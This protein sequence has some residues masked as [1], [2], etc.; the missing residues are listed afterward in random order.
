MNVRKTA[1][2]TDIIAHLSILHRLLNICI[3]TT[4][5]FWLSSDGYLPLMNWT[6]KQKTYDAK[7]GEEIAMQIRS[8]V[9]EDM[10]SN[11]MAMIT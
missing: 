3:N 7:S 9:F 11:T 4:C 5:D 8:A 1:V 6:K 10:L 2:L